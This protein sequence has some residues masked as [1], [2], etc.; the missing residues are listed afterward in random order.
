ML[1]AQLN[2]LCERGEAGR[3]GVVLELL[4][5]RVLVKASVH[6]GI[7]IGG[8]TPCVAHTTSWPAPD[9]DPCS[10]KLGQHSRLQIGWVNEGW[11][12]DTE[13]EGLNQF[14]A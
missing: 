11:N 2:K 5:C 14:S 10:R 1:N 4:Q 7:V 9:G 12:V 13:M 6:V 3:G 8:G